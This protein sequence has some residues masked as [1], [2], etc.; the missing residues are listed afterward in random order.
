MYYQGENRGKISED[1]AMDKLEEMFQS[2][3][4]VNKKNNM[5]FI[6]ALIFSL[7][8]YLHRKR[9]MI[10]LQVLSLFTGKR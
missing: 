2:L 7:T 3:K 8:Y 6:I 4:Q 9:K 5:K 1:Q 10:K